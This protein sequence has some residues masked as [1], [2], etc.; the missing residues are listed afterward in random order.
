MTWHLVMH[1]LG[2]DDASGPVY[3][4]WSGF[5]SDISELAIV[6][7]VAG[8]LR[9]HNCEVKGCPRLGRHRTAAGHRVCRRH[10]PDGHLT[11]E[12]VSALHQDARGGAAAPD[13][14][15]EAK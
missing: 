11:A 2:L 5:G 12:A 14:E 9:Q 8:M 13:D 6:G 7:G 3:L 15:G 10:H 1:W 4:A